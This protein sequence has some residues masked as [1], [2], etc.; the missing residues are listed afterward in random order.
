M[1]LDAGLFDSLRGLTAQQLDG[2]D[3]LDRLNGLDGLNSLTSMG[4]TA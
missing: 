1:A 2:I 4:S 3:G